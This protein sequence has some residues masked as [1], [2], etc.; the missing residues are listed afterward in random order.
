MLL[1]VE[2]AIAEVYS[3]LRCDCWFYVNDQ[4]SR[5]ISC[6]ERRAKGRTAIRCTVSFDKDVEASLSPKWKKACK[7]VEK[8]SF[9]GAGGLATRLWQLQYFSFHLLNLVVEV[10]IKVYT[11]CCHLSGQKRGW[12]SRKFAG[13]RTKVMLL[14]PVVCCVYSERTHATGLQRST[15]K[16][17]FLFARQRHEQ[18]QK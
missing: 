1:P 11:R 12:I 8:W 18:L 3:I 4:Y 2:Y 17:A 10:R 15:H 16:K 9:V 6:P 13:S 5:N 14:R 7:H